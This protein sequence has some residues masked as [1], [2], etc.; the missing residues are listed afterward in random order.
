MPRWTLDDIPWSRFRPKAVDPELLAVVKAAALVERN[1]DDYARYLGQVFDDDS[2]FRDAVA[3]WA[4]EEAQH[5]EALRRWAELADPGFDFAQALRR[6][7][8]GYSLPLDAPASVRGSRSGELIAR[9]IVETGTSS[10]YAA[11]GEAA[12][13]P[14]L[15]EICR[16]I[17]ADELRHYKLF[18]D[19]LRRYRARERPGLLARTAVALGRLREVDDDELAFAWHAANE[20]PERPYVRAACARAYAASA[21]AHYRRHHVREA[22]GL[23]L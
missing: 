23:I 22:V 1:A 6:F 2:V 17:R 16:R 21:F 5:G 7:R 8:A 12:R 4:E 11:L 19:H 20:P 13:E 15:A 14:V 3:R 10:H 9:C 18:Y